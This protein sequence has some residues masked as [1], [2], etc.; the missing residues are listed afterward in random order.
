[1]VEHSTEL[2]SGRWASRLAAVLLVVLVTTACVPSGVQPAPSREGSA[3]PKTLSPAGP[4]RIVA[5]IGRDTSNLA[6]K[7]ASTGSFEGDQQ[8]MINSPLA[9]IDPRGSTHPRLALDL[10]SR[11]KRTWVVKADGTMETTWTIR[12]NAVWHDGQPV[13]SQDFVFALNVYLD[14]AMPVRERAPE[15]LMDRIE[16]QDNKT[17]TIHWK[18]TYPWADRLLL[19][20]LEPLPVHILG[21]LYDS[22]K[23]AFVTASFWT[24]SS[25]VSSG[26]YRLAGW[27][28]GVQIAYRAFENYFLGRPK[29][30]EIILRVIP[31][32]NTVVANVLS[33]AI[34]TTI[35]LAL[36]EQARRTVQGQWRPEEGQ[37]VGYP[38]L[39]RFTQ[40]Q[41]H[42]ERVQ[43]QALLDRRV[44]RAIVHAL[45]RPGIAEALMGD[46]SL[47]TDVLL[48]PS[49]PVYPRVQQVIAKYPYDPTRALAL[50]Q[51]AG[52]T[53]AGDRVVDARGQPFS[54]N[55]RTGQV[56]DNEIQMALMASYLSAIG[57]DISQTPAPQALNSDLEFRATFPGLHATGTS[58]EMPGAMIAF[59]TEQCP[60]AGRGYLGRNL[61]C[62]DNPEFDHLFDIATS[63]LDDQERGSAL[64]NMFR[65][66]LEDVGS[67][68]LSYVSEWLATRK[69]LVGPAPRWPTQAGG[70]TWNVHEWSWVDRP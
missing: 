10:P 5:A 43:Q 61:G 39:V 62:W 21:N 49:E 23:E 46:A 17:F 42:P 9:V 8:F 38:A 28:K 50:L 67:F 7:F 69:G 20:Q 63:T 29:L 34:D 14:D 4:S 1:M 65:V 47:A 60:R 33:G 27:D 56:S 54:L 18:Q 36:N 16:L 3:G 24:S 26:P 12:P 13:T 25:Y 11:D 48:S 22:G 64:V 35:S 55:V 37:V 45:D 41:L 32:M 58:L 70:T 44:R 59:T 2:P 53:R 51:E 6:S 57:M 52:W 68:G 40:I 66:L 15:R 30:D 31:D 19:G